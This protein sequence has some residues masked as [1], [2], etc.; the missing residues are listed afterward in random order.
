M[1][2]TTFKMSMTTFNIILINVKWAWCS[3]GLWTRLQ[4]YWLYHLSYRVCVVCDANVTV[5]LQLLLVT[6]T[7]LTADAPIRSSSFSLVSS[8]NVHL[9]RTTYCRLQRDGNGLLTGSSQ[10]YATILLHIFYTVTLHSG[11]HLTVH[12]Y[13]SLSL[14]IQEML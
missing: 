1:S 8:T 4:L 7:L 13:V 9:P 3:C 2:M 11:L 12:M 10:K 14:L 6:I 5:L